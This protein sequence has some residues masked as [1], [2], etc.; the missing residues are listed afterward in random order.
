[1]KKLRF[2]IYALLAFC[3][4][5]AC[6]Y[7]HVLPFPN[8]ENYEG[9]GTP[10]LG[11]NGSYILEPQQFKRGGQ[12]PTIFEVPLNVPNIECYKA[13]YYLT[14][15]NGGGKEAVSSAIIS[16]DGNVIFRQ[17]D[18][19]KKM[20]G[21]VTSVAINANSV[22]KIDVRGK[23]GSFITV[24]I[25][26]TNSPCTW[27]YSYGGSEFDYPGN[28][29]GT[30]NGG[31]IF[32]GYSE[33][34]DGD[35]L[36]PTSTWVVKLDKN[37][38]IEWQ[39]GFEGRMGDE[40]IFQS[41][42]D[43]YIITGRDGSIKLSSSGDVQWLSH[44][45]GN[46]VIQN[47]KQNYIILSGSSVSELST[48]GDLL[49][50]KSLNNFMAVCILEDLIAKEGY[51]IGG[52]NMTGNPDMNLF[53]AL[54]VSAVGEELWRNSFG[55]TTSWDYP[56]DIIQKKDGGFILV[57]SWFRVANI[58]KDGSLKWF[59]YILPDDPQAGNAKSIIFS[60]D[61]YIVGGI[62]WNPNYNGS[63]FGNVDGWVTKINENG[64][65]IW[66]KYIGGSGEENI[67][68]IVE[69]E[70]NWY[71]VG[72]YNFALRNSN[73]RLMDYWAKKIHIE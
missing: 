39:A 25:E 41:V 10:I 40:D 71:V 56:N 23:P 54:K 34:N 21:L 5:A 44:I 60:G 36:Y 17:S 73:N 53:G 46:T 1:M 70:P 30:V 52:T 62:M 9:V 66:E 15:L 14:V 4:I 59:K 31:F 58:N 12:E 38:L 3:L 64:D 72:G 20:R 33:S 35:V 13:P 69:I 6:E 24:A 50:T 65:K 16:I 68:N 61:D 37:G 28:F 42:D 63:E 67:E 45:G 18:F 51:L 29:I 11:E 8:S 19:K 47:L 27:E 57:G 55:E 32:T 49:W 2:S 7:L 22:L 48:N 26:G 43:G